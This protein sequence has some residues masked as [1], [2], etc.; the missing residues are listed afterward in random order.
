VY[1]IRDSNFFDGP[2]TTHNLDHGQ[3]LTV[4]NDPILDLTIVSRERYFVPELQ[5]AIAAGRNW[6]LTIRDAGE[7]P[8]RIRR[9]G[10]GSHVLFVSFCGAMDCWAGNEEPAPALL[11]SKRTD[12]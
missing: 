3:C 4:K 1:A 7:Q 8:R 9:L 2:K 6:W 11:I 10:G 12:S 5:K